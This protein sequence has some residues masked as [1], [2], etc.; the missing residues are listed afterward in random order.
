MRQPP[1]APGIVTCL[2]IAL[3]TTMP[4]PSV[5][6]A[7]PDYQVDLVVF[8]FA[9]PHDDERMVSTPD[10]PDTAGAIRLEE[11]RLPEGFEAVPSSD[12]A[13]ADVVATI[14]RSSRYRLLGHF[15]WRQPGMDRDT[16]PPVRVHG[17]ND[18]TEAVRRQYL[19]LPLDHP[20]GDTRISRD[21]VFEQFDGTV[22]L[23]KGRYLHI[24]TDLVYRQPEIVSVHDAATGAQTSR[25]ELHQYPVRS[26][27]RMRSGE[28]HYIDHPLL[29][30]LVMVTRLQGASTPPEPETEPEPEESD[31]QPASPAN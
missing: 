21:T 17:G 23:G 11:R 27:R 20:M 15:I 31:G 24:D 6:G 8:T 26:H 7:G 3:L 29:G 2:L 25:K 19:A 22:T 18:Y 1:H 13:I 4:V 28:L 10:T 16:A 9:N 12:S 30:I 14:K 5:Y